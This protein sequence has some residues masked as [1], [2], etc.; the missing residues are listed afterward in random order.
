MEAPPEKQISVGWTLLRVASIWLMSY[1]GYY[2][3]LPVFGFG[4]GYNGSPVAI[5]VYYI[6]WIVVSLITF[7]HI[8][9]DWRPIENRLNI[10]LF[11]AVS[12]LGMA[13]FA[14]YAIPNLPSIVWTEPWAPP[15]LMVAN[16]WY[17]LPKAAEIFLQQLLIAAL[18]LTFFERNYSMRSIT[19]W[20][21]ILFGGAHFL[22]AFGGVPAGY[23]IRF[24]LSAAIFGA[25]FP[26]L[27]LRVPNGFAYSYTLHW[28]Y[29]AITIVMAH[30]VSPYAVF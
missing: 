20:C 30:T 1:I 3:F 25:I 17:F 12:F 8:F 28:V 5:T 27:I 11:L 26:R 21:V 24:T 4:S 18:V 2:A 15:E 22:L 9:E 23:V 29:Y 16:S 19:W 10:F 6:F 7:R 14:A 13:I